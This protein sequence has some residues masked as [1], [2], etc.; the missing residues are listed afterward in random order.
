MFCK[1]SKT[2]TSR[3]FSE[4]RRLSERP[5]IHATMDFGEYHREITEGIRIITPAI[6]IS[7]SAQEHLMSCETKQKS[8]GSLVSICDFACQSVIMHGLRESFPGDR[9]LGEESIDGESDAFLRMVRLLLPAEIDPVSACRDGIRFISE[10]DHRVWVIDP[11]DGTYGFVRND[12]YAIAIA[13]LVDLRVRACIVAWPRA[14]SEFTGVECD[15]PVIL[16][17]ASGYGAA[18]VDLGGTFHAVPTG[19]PPSR[20]VHSAGKIPGD[21]EMQ[22]CVK[23][24]LAIDEIVEMVSMTKAFTVACRQACLYV[25]L[26]AKIKGLDEAVWDIAPFDLFVRE[27][28][29]FVTNWDGTPVEYT[30][31]GTV[32]G[33]RAGMI[34]TS[35]DAEFHQRVLDLYRE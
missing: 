25:R 4:R 11:I 18:I 7:L 9:V 27:C 20:M 14:R 2:V 12:N 32:K 31:Q 26:S 21:R 24:A 10:A 28:G 19:P 5:P 16:V 17:A 3:G 15:G 35:R 29:G 22:L 13:L 34:I 1:V 30:R 6:H 23:D 33:T 8:D